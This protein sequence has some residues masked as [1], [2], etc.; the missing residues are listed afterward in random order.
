MSDVSII[1]GYNVKDAVSRGAIYGVT[2][3]AL[4]TGAGSGA[5]INAYTPAWQAW[6][7][8][9]TSGP[10]AKIKLG[11]VDYTSNAIP[12]ASSSASGVVTTGNQTFSGRKTMELISPKI[13]DGTGN[14]SRYKYVYFAN[15]AGSQVGAVRYDSG[16]TTNVTSGMFSLLQYS[17]NSTNNTSTTGYYESYNLPT[18]NTGLS[19]NAA[20]DVVTTK[21]ITLSSS[22]YGQAIDNAYLHFEA[23]SSSSTPFITALSMPAQT[24]SW[25]ISTYPGTDETF[26]FIYNNG[27]GTSNSNTKRFCLDPSVGSLNN[28][29]EIITSAHEASTTV[30]GIVTTGAQQF[31]GVKTFDALKYWGNNGSGASRYIGD[32]QYYT[33]A[34]NKV[35]EVYYD[36]GNATTVSSGRFNFLAYS[37]QSTAGATTTGFYEDFRLPTPTAGLSANAFYDILT[38]KTLW[39][40]QSL[41]HCDYNNHVHDP[42]SNGTL[43]YWNGRYGSDASNLTYYKNGTI[44]GSGEMAWKVQS[45]TFSTGYASTITCSGVKS[46]STILATCNTTFTQYRTRTLSAACYSTTNTIKMAL[47][48]NTSSLTETMAIF[49]TK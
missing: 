29:Y 2:S 24:G 15:N 9:T 32:I 35:A 30:A 25:G 41:G 17:P 18:V 42:I 23:P 28:S 1:N 11:N 47:T 20:Y 33:N 14:E 6:V 21:P 48:T 39:D 3:G 38:T 46:T 8:G 44:Y 10:Q 13:Y 7:A 19:A 36:I 31:R 12:S 27:G 5:V 45:V 4:L 22:T 34:G 16:S 49:W 26:I 37:P 43:A 40:M